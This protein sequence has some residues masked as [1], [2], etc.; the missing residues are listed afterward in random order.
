MTYEDVLIGGWIHANLSMID[1]DALNTFHNRPRINSLTS[2]WIA[3]RPRLYTAPFEAIVDTNGRILKAIRKGPY[4][5]DLLTSFPQGTSQLNLTKRVNSLIAYHDDNDPGTFHNDTFAS[6]W[7]PYLIKTLG[8][9]TSLDPEKPAPDFATIAPAMED[10]YKRLVAIILGLHPNLF[11]PADKSSSISGKT[12]ITSKRV[13]MSEPMWYISIV[14][15]SL[16]HSGS[17]HLL[18]QETK[19]DS[20]EDANDRSEYTRAV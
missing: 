5:R 4:D 11:L 3:C 6:S 16:E 18:R 7:V 15:L 12:T 1:S 20:H 14:L 10:L 2:T 13:V 9:S 17:R 19:A 8:A